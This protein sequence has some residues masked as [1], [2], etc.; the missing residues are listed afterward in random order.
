[1]SRMIWVRHGESRAN[2]LK[3]LSC[4]KVDLPLTD[5]GRLQ[6]EQTAAVLSRLPVSGVFASPL[7]RAVETAE[8][9]AAP[10]RLPVTVL[11]NF[12]EVQ[13]G[14]LEDSGSRPESWRQYYETLAAWQ[15]GAFEL[16][17]PGGEDAC[18]VRRRLRAGIEH[19]LA[20]GDPWGVKVIVGH[21]GIFTAGLP[22]LCR[23]QDVSGY[24][25][26]ELH[27]CAIGE[28]EMA[29]RPEGW[30]GRVLRW[31]DT[32]HLSGKAARQAS[33]SMNAIAPGRA[34]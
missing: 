25:A 33:V 7:L 32:S 19:I 4:R 11:D 10:L 26:A 29:R 27:N 18:M 23:G 6:A 3:L 22:E 17:F 1:M 15:A 20:A 8:I 5:K 28:L 16:R 12:I 21:A 31:A 14:E 34:G 30:A 24:L 9:I 13:L 2:I